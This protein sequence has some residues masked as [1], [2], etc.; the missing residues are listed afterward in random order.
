LQL[1]SIALGKDLENSFFTAS[2]DRISTRRPGHRN[3]PVDGRGVVFSG[4]TREP[5]VKGLTR[6]HSAKLFNG[7]I[8]LSNSG[9]GEIGYVKEG[10]FQPTVRTNGWT[11]GLAFVGG[12]LFAGTSKVLP[13]FSQ[14]APGLQVNKSVCGIHAIDPESGTVMGSMM[15]PTANQIFAIEWIPQS[16]SEGLP[17]VPGRAS[18]DTAREIFYDFEG[19]DGIARRH[20]E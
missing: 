2:S 11:R 14:Y 1:N 12:V 4:K 5:I 17:F 8:W 3:F 15:W 20:G 18:E 19:V 13:R 6:P 16:V 7:R 9:Y 10:V